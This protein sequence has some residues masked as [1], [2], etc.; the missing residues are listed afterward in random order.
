V[1]NDKMLRDKNLI[2]LSHQHQHA[3]AFCVRLDRALAKG[4]ADLESWQEEMVSIWE[5]EI[6]F[7]F[8]AE[9]KVLFPA[10]DK[11]ASLRP[12]VKQ[13]LSE[14]VTLRDFFASAK[15][16]R[17]DAAGMKTFGQTLSQHIRTEEHQLFEECQHQMPTGEMA[18]AGAA[19]EKYFAKSGMPG[20]SC[21]LPSSSKQTKQK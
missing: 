11:Y 1:D 8:E 12:L 4:A 7:H 19:M 3:L 20:A 5:S 21:A 9:E 17:L 14:H 2:P 16:R 15:A 6:R 10:A 13:L 18:R